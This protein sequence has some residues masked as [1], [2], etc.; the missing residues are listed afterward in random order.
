M[1]WR[2]AQRRIAEARPRSSAPARLDPSEL[3]FLANDTGTPYLAKIDGAGAKK[4]ARYKL[5]WKSTRGE[6]C[7]WS[8]T[9]RAT[10][11]A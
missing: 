8:E 9:A 7:P 11:G 5:R 1:T 2:D 4:I 10:V 6:T 3:T